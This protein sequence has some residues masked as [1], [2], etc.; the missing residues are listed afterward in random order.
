MILPEEDLR[1]L[2]SS[3]PKYEAPVYLS[4]AQRNRSDLIRIPMYKPGKEDATRIEYRSPDPVCNPYLAFSVML[5]A[6]LAGVAEKI[7]PSEPVEDNVYKMSPGE[8]KRRGI[9]QLPGSLLEAIRRP[10]KSKVVKEALGERVFNR[11]IENKK[12]EWDR[13]RIQ[14]TSYE[15]EKYL[16]VL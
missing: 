6:G 13:Y 14:I 2:K 7:Q 11:F 10:E 12:M 4:W 15:L 16:P 1:I 3:F 5:A 9:A 8:R